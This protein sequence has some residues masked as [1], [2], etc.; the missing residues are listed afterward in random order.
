MAWELKSGVK[1]NCLGGN[2]SWDIS[3]R[4]SVY[5]YRSRIFE[6]VHSAFSL[7]YRVPTRVATGIYYISAADIG[8]L[9]EEMRIMETLSDQGDRAER[10]L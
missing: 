1:K 7:M 2:L 6:E 5:G 8:A 9:S 4:V 10:T 3:F